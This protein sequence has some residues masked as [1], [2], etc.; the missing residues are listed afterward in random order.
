VIFGPVQS[1]AQATRDPQAVAAGCYVDVAG[2]QGEIRLP[3]TP[4]D[5]ESHRPSAR[6]APAL[7]ADGNAIREELGIETAKTAA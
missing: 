4:I 1:G 6:L 3:A 7:D 2:P 5:F